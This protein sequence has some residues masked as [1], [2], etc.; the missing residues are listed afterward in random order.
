M[1]KTKFAAKPDASNQASKKQSTRNRD[2]PDKAPLEK[3]QKALASPKKA[4]PFLSEAAD[5]ATDG[6][7]KPIGL[8]LASAHILGSACLLSGVSMG[9]AWGPAAMGAVLG[10]LYA[11]LNRFGM[12]RFWRMPHAPL[13]VVVTGGTKGLGKAIARE[14][15]RSGDRV[16]VSSRS[17][18]AVRKAMNE[19]RDEVGPAIWIGGIDCDVSSPASVQRLTDG[20]A[21][22]M[23]SIDVWINNAGFSGSFQSFL[24]ASPE[25]IQEVVQTN[26]LGCLLCTRAAMRL[27][28]AQPRGG[29]IFNMDG[30]GA[31]GL[32]TPQ[33][34]AYG[35]T[36]AG[37]AHL[38]GSLKAEPACQ[39]ARVG[40]HCLS[41]G[42]VLTNLLLEGASDTNKQIFNILCEQPETVAAFLV[43]RAR[44]VAARGEAGR[45]IRFLTLP[46]ALL[47]FIAAPL[48]ANRFFNA[49]GEPMYAAE[50]ERILGQR[51]R[52]TERL[53]AAA[54]RRSRN[55]AF[56]YSASLATAYAIIA[57]DTLTHLTP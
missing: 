28:A 40:V 51:A 37:I 12:K 20:A 30:A 11:A 23:G 34:A 32:P 48:R 9:G 7:H 43:P 49:D 1:S 16:M 47:R 41:P 17:V 38:L 39:R 26:L 14:F 52:R 44:T 46:R 10:S 50:R 22:Q 56:A 29:H 13:N 31:D 8:V 19:L 24:D 3:L 36:K 15:L 5:R 33:Y 2:M 25:Q 54:A 45:Y 53:A 55:L 27:M 42:M 18:Q 4:L 57:A 35:A 21:S 6:L